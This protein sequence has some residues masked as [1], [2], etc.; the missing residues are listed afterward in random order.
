MDFWI[1]NS[2]RKKRSYIE[3]CRLV[4]FQQRDRQ[5]SRNLNN[6]TFWRPP[7]TSAQCVIGTEKYPDS[8]ILLIYDDYDYS[9][10]CGRI[11]KAFRAL[12][13][14]DILKP[15]LSDNQFRSSNN[16][17]DFWY[18][19]NRFDIRYHIRNL[20]N[21][22]KAGVVKKFRQWLGTLIAGGSELLLLRK[23]FKEWVFR[24]AICCF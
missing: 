5:D 17:N 8:A 24:V 9:Q 16:G 22:L 21:Q 7:V 12:T 19:L 10:G 23:I 4:G 3:Y 13:K 2:R 20:L 18:K 14:D 15:F 6:H 1:G 11:K